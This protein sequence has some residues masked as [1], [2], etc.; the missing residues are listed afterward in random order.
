MAD[1][2]PPLAGVTIVERG[3]GLAAAYAG[4]LLAAFGADV[5]RAEPPA[6][7]AERVL[8]RNKRRAR[9]VAAD[10]TI[11]DESA[12]PPDAPDAVRCRITTWGDAGPRRTLPPD[13]ALVAAGTGVHA[14][15]WSWAKRPVWLVTPVV[16]Y[17]TGMLAA[18]GVTAALFARRRGAPAQDV[19]VSG[20]G[21]AFALSSG[22][23]VTG[24]GHRGSLLHQG[25]PRGAYPTYS[26]YPTADGWLMVGALT[27]AFWVKLMTVV[28]RVDLLAHPQLQGNPMAFGVPEVR[29]M[30]RDALGPVFR[31]R[32]TAEWVAVL[33]EADIPCGAVGTRAG[34]LADPE[35]RALGLAIPL[36][37]PVLGP[38]WQPGIPAV[39]SDTPLPAPMPF[40]DGTAPRRRADP[41]PRAAEPPRACLAG[42]RV[43][44]LSS[45]I[46]G[47]FCPMLLADLGADVVKV[48]TL[49]GDPFR[50]AAFGFPGWN[51]GKRSLALDL[52]RPEGRAVLLDL[53][54]TA[55]LVVDNF[56]GGVLERLGLG[57]ETLRAANPRLIHLSITGYG[58]DGPLATLPGF[59]PVFQ[60]RSGLMQA[61]GGDDE[62]V[63]HTIPYTDY[64]AGAL[65]ALAAVAALL[66]RERT[67]RGQRVD[68]SLFRTAFVAQ[69][70][71]MLAA[72]GVP[73][74]EVGGRD[75]LGPSPDRRLYECRDG[76][77]AIAAG[78]AAERAALARVAGGDA[79]AIARALG[80]GTRAAALARLAAAGVPAA[81]CVTFDE[82]FTDEHLRA[83]GCV[84]E[85]DDPSLGRIRMGGPLI[86]FAATPIVYQRPAPGLGADGPAVLREAGYDDARIAALVDAGVVGRG[87]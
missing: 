5:V 28:D 40:A 48:E 47:P 29:T 63:F 74:P 19:A 82:V 27:E 81:P 68:V 79:A 6:T 12:S 59:D 84:V 41:A 52:K 75:W 33:R 55:D 57:W 13:E 85:Q 36:V 78:T 17:M 77:I 10:A 51:R 71:H 65:A 24:P 86:H 50:L 11:G 35:A 80:G 42:I 53:A 56:R 1:P 37:D 32:T 34:F 60:A 69:A 43:L 9:E 39:F 16:G 2:I 76:W 21:G 20:L 44:D 72:A 38:T 22:T 87:A 54:R 61:Q 3:R 64:S 23:Y 31:T 83:N 49:E 58:S 7:P 30:V 66:A 73:E 67:G 4:F 8:H 46:A 14:G 70:A 45:F 15:Q 26:L 18:L 62:P 25:D